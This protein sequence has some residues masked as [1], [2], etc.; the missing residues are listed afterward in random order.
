M[1]PPTLAPRQTGSRHN[2]L[3]GLWPH[4]N[5]QLRRPL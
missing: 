3:I 4:L 1:Q 5:R 2:G